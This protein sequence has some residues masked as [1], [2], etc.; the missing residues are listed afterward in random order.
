MRNGTGPDGTSR[1][2]IVA[3]IKKKR[4]A[5]SDKKSRRKYRALAA[6]KAAAEAEAETD[7]TASEAARE[8]DDAPDAA[9]GSERT[10]D[11]LHHTADQSTESSTK[12]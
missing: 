10:G 2:S 4:R 5:S 1:T 11:G 8:M 12:H 9:Y 7:A 3:A 6:A